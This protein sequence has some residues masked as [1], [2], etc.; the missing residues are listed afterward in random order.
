MSQAAY[1]LLFAAALLVVVLGE[2]LRPWRS[3]AQSLA[4]RWWNHGLLFGI[5]TV[6]STLIYRAALPAIS[7]L[8]AH[9]RFGL[10]NKSWLPLA[11]RGVLAFLLIDL[12]RYTVHRAFHSMPLLWRVH[13]VHH[14]DSELDLSTGI[15]NHPL[16]AIAGQA[17]L[18]VVIAV[19]A[20]PP[21][22]VLVIE[23]AALLSAF[24]T[25]A[26]ASLPAWLERCL[27]WIFVTPQMHRIHHSEEIG[28]QNANFGEIVPWW[29]RIFGTYQRTPAA[30][31]DQM[32]TGLKEAQGEADTSLTLL[33]LEPFQSTKGQPARPLR[34]SPLQ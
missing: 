13:Q 2:A 9:N 4:R 15:R 10:L 6:V 3:V 22:A 20:P 19:L 21:A 5:S 30:G 27:G 11:A 12:T 32:R 8:A 7:I 23:M 26:N 14:S 29:D 1:S 24:F 34:A 17:V 31:F 18:G 25:H 16:E 33:L 28:E